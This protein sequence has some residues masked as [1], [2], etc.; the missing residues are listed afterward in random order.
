MKNTVADAE[1]PD[2]SNHSPVNIGL[3]G[4]CKATD[5]HD[6][7]EM[8]IHSNCGQRDSRKTAHIMLKVNG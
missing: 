2:K 5:E 7:E 6:K 8:C 1:A 4:M 3:R